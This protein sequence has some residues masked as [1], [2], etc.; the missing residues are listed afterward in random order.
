MAKVLLATHD[1]TANMTLLKAPQKEKGENRS[2]GREGF[3]PRGRLRG[4][5]GRMR[6]HGQERDEGNLR[7]HRKNAVTEDWF[8]T[9]FEPIAFF[10]ILKICSC[11][12]M[13]DNR[14]TSAAKQKTGQNARLISNQSIVLSQTLRIALTTSEMTRKARKRK[15]N[16]WAMPADVPAIPEKPSTPAIMATTRNTRA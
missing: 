9:F 8:Q 3:S 13:G 7:L 6:R 12:D 4:V 15:N 11:R 2:G 14:F 5:K 16:I 10:P 1:R